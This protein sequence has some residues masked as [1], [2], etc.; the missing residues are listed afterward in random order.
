MESERT[1]QSTSAATSTLGMAAMLSAVSSVFSN[2]TNDESS[3]NSESE[4]EYSQATGGDAN[5]SSSN[6]WNNENLS[7]SQVR[8]PKKANQA[9]RVEPLF[10]FHHDGAWRDEIEVEIQTKNKKKFTGTITPI[11]AKHQ[12]YIGG[13]GF[14]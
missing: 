8:S 1:K 10:D 11:E 12:I 7:K 5:L 14:R 6:P 4:E 13:N 2:N 3:Q 9:G